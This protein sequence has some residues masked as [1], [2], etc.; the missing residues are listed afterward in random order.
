MKLLGSFSVNFSKKHRMRIPITKALYDAVQQET[1]PLII[2]GYTASGACS[3]SYMSV[4]GNSR[5]TYKDGA[6][7]RWDGIGYRTPEFDKTWSSCW[8]DSRHIS[9]KSDFISFHKMPYE[10]ECT[11]S[12]I[13]LEA[14]SYN[15]YDKGTIQL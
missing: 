3:F 4:S 13:T 10:R 11:I 15:P 7:R 8:H 5:W 12:V 2:T 1:N 9:I 14:L 6:N